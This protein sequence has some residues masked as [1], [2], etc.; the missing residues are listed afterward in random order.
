MLTFAQLSDLHLDNGP[1]ATARARQVVDYLRPLAG[2]LDAVLVT[3]DLADHGLAEEYKELA[4]LLDLPCP[5]LMTPGNHDDRAVYRQ[6]LLGQ[7]ASQEPINSV[8]DIGGVRFAL[9]DSS[10]P[11]RDDGWLADE[12]LA[13]LDS[14]LGDGPSFVCFHH[15]PVLLH[16]W[17]DGIRQFGAERLEAVIARHPG[18]VAVLCGHAHT[19][20]ATTFAGRPLVVCPGVVS[21]LVLPVED[22]REHAPG[23]ALH[24]LDDERRLTTFYRT[25]V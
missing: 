5:V 7:A 22:K 2:E 18:V 3:G 10:I 24:V 13:W 17:V 21:T 9:C 25:V 15:P 8:H 20:G 1:R 4:D 11:G 6:V 16:S 23:L 14:V 19:A 12:T